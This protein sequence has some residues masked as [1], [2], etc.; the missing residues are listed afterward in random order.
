MSPSLCSSSREFYFSNVVGFYCVVARRMPVA[1]AGW[2]Y[3]HHGGAR[4]DKPDRT[5]AMLKVVPVDE[6]FY[7]FTRLLDVLEAL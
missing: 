6:S 3:L 1:F 2:R 4:G 5:M 7:P